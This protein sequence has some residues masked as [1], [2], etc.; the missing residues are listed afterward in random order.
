MATLDRILVTTNW[1]ARYPLARTF[2]LPKVVRDHKPLMTTF[3]ET[4]RGGDTI[5]R[6]EKWWLEIEGFENLVKDTWS[7]ECPLT[8]PVDRWQFKMRS[9]WKR[10][11][12]WSAN[13]DA[14]RKRNMK[15]FMREL[16]ELDSKEDKDQLAEQELKRKK[17]LVGL[18]DH[19]WKV[20]ELRLNKGQ[21][22]GRSR[23]GIGIHPI[24]LPRL[25][26]GKGRRL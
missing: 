7:R 8:N 13:L 14:E 5:F 17:E 2:M 1:E 18:M 15:N 3:G 10:I 26:R 12:G 20:E 16:D 6:F 23:K 19:I 24:S 4:L 25:I 11:R 21:E 22:R 9:M